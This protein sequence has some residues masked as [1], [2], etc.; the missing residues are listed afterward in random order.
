[1]A[2][3]SEHNSFVDQMNRLIADAEHR[4]SIDENDFQQLEVCFAFSSLLW[5]SH[6]ATSTPQGEPVPAADLNAS[7]EARRRLARCYLGVIT[8]Q[9]QHEIVDVPRAKDALLHH[10]SSADMLVALVRRAMLELGPRKSD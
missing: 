1:M 10:A 4:Q 7:Q 9:E 3:I 6:K 5:L 2:T 8:G